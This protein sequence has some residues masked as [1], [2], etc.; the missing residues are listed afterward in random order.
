MY[1]AIWYGCTIYYALYWILYIWA[2]Y[3]SMEI[4]YVEVN[5]CES[6]VVD[7]GHWP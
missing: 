3:L 2:Y 5:A 1:D 6:S 4:K 7:V